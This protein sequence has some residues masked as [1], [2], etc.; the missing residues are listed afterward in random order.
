[1]ARIGHG[2]RLG[3]LLLALT[4]PAGAAA[5]DWKVGGA[6][7]QEGV[8]LRSDEGDSTQDQLLSISSFSLS[9]QAIDGADV[10]TF[11]P[12][13]SLR[14]N[15]GDRDTNENILNLTGGF[16]AGFA[17][18]GQRLTTNLSLG[19]TVER[20]DDNSTALFFDPDP[21]TGEERR[22]LAQQQDS[23]LQVTAQTGLGFSYALDPRQ[24][25][26][27]GVSYQ[28]RFFLD[29]VE[30]LDTFSSVSSNAGY[31]RSLSPRLSASLSTSARRFMSDAE[32]G[33]DST[34]LT[35]SSGANYS[36]DPSQ[37]LG[38]TLGLTGTD[39]GET[40][41]TSFSGGATY[42]YAGDDT[43]LNLSL[44]QSVDQ[45]EDGE[46]VQI[47]ALRGSL[48]HR[49][50]QRSRVSLGLGM[51]IETPI[52]GDPGNP[53]F[54]VAPTFQHDLSPQWAVAVGYQLRASSTSDADNR[55]FAR[56]S[57]SFSI[58]D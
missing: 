4:S 56:I 5:A 14:L 12:R 33:S 35:L 21:V 38:V 24:S 52:G 13:V 47:L 7:S 49:L 26:N 37:N 3:A 50:T 1:M 53:D 31:R 48:G 41:D 20:A 54:L 8:F 11:N 27:G 58:L 44:S 2:Q 23:A 39:D 6:V 15:G 46:V 25:V 51:T 42:G 36:L 10:L 43:T 16:S 32:D 19:A 45:N 30:N 40:F 9:T 17:R 55:V 18:T 22:T 34:S 29:D 57:R 28:R